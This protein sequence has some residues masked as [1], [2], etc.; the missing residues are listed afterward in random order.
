PPGADEEGLPAPRPQR[1]PPRGPPERRR[2]HRRARH[3]PRR[4][5]RR[6]F[7]GPPLALDVLPGDA[8]A[9]RPPPRRAG[10][11][12]ARTRAGAVRPPRRRGG[13]GG[14]DGGRALRGPP[15]AAPTYGRR[16]PRRPRGRGAAAAALR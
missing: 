7:D 12:H 2:L 4:P 16:P 10:G 5:A 3:P 9:P 11:P 1:L 15:L 14:L 6:L 13:R 8:R